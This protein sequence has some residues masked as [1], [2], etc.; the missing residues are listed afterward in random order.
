MPSPARLAAVDPSPERGGVQIVE[1]EQ[2]IAEVPFRIDG[3][4][5]NA[6]PEQLLDEHDAQPGLSGAGHADDETVREQVPRIEADRLARVLGSWTALL[7]EIEGGFHR[8]SVCHV[9]D[10]VAQRGHTV[11]ALAAKPCTGRG[12]RMPR[13][14]HGGCSSPPWVAGSQGAGPEGGAP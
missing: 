10:S 2:E 4:D 11:A 3:H 13:P 12:L 7:A 1:Q 14:R 5:R 9:T 8:G 6:L